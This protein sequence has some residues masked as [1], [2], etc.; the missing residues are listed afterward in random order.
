MLRFSLIGK[1]PPATPPLSQKVTLRR[2]KLRFLRFLK[3]VARYA[4][5]PLPQSHIGNPIVCCKR[6]HDFAVTSSCSARL[7]LRRINR[8]DARRPLRRQI[9]AVS[10]AAGARMCRQLF[11][12][13]KGSTPTAEMP[14]FFMWLLQTETGRIHVQSLC[15]CPNEALAI[16]ILKI[17]P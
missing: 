9:L 16:E 6:P 15:F 8:L 10:R 13:Y 12:S 14:I 1:H 7:W 5:F 17:S 3:S 11:A 4:V 2:N